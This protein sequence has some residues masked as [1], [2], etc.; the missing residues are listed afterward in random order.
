MVAVIPARGGSKGV[1]GKNVTEVG[2]RPLV[3][4]AVAAARAAGHVDRVLVSTDD[5]LIASAARDAGAEIVDRPVALADDTATSESALRHALDT[6]APEAEVVLLVQCTSPFLSADDVDGVAA[7]VLGGA[8]SAFTAAVSHGFLWRPD[9]TGV[10]HDPAT[11][12]RRQDRPVELLETGAAYAMRVDGFRR[13]GHRFFGRVVPVAVDPARTLEIDEPADLDRARL[14][15][16]LVDHATSI[17]LADVDALVLDFD[18]TLTDDRV[19][20]DQD[21]RESVTVHRGDGLGIAALRRAGL[22]V[23]ILSTEQ[24]PVVSARARKLNIPALQGIEA[25][26]VA[27]AQWCADHGHDLARTAYVGND[28]NDLPC[29]DIVGWP[30]AVADAHHSVR[31]RARIVTAAAGGHGAIREVASR[32][33]GKEIRDG[34]DS[35]A[36]HR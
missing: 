28:V 9:G 15:A 32:L 33:L 29:F 3:A 8:D 36:L 10:N 26:G 16:P 4:R 21:G 5:P 34:S 23:V 22:A 13:T 14:L 11:R 27:L 30:I 18:G 1:P 2:G 35:L 31:A 24:N 17:G 19:V 6:A 25:K 12:P 7:A 20:V